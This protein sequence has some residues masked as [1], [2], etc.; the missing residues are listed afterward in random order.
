MQKRTWKTIPGKSGILYREHPLR[1]YNRKPDRFYAIRRTLDGKRIVETLG[2]ASEGW[3][4]DMAAAVLAE[5]KMNVKLG[6]GPRTLAEKRAQAM[7]RAEKE[8][9]AAIESS[10]RRMTFAELAGHYRVWALANRRDGKNVGRMLDMHILPHLG[11]SYARDVTPA[12]INTLRDT[13]AVKAPASG[14][15]ETLSPQTVMHCLKIIREVYNYAAETAHPDLPGIMLFSGPNPA[16]MRKRGRGVR[17]PRVDNRRLRILTGAEIEKMLTFAP[18]SWHAAWTDLRSMI[19]FSLDTGLRSGELG[20]LRWEDVNLE[21]GA[22]NVIHGSDAGTTKSGRARVVYAGQLFPE[23]LT[24]LRGRPQN[25]ALV[26]P[27]RNGRPRDN[28]AV[29]RAMRKIANALDLN[30]GV[31]DNRNRVVWHT[32]RHTYATLWLERGLDIYTLKELMGHHSVTVTEGYLHLC[33]K[34]KRALALAALA[35]KSPEHR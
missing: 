32:L 21:T 7:E 33:D 34:A 2:W 26:F 27:G 25:T 4:I 20:H 15:G 6:L 10:L 23:C 8:R 24:M 3:T 12:M 17:A 28:S 29:S 22:I 9:N 14:R 19:L 11:Q 35:V 18:D 30:D 5:L 1:K 16:V 31:T 13:L